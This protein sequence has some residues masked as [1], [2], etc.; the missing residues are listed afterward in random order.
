MDPLK[1]LGSLLGNNATSSGP[2]GQIL[3]QLLDG[4][5]RGGVQSSGAG[6]GLTDLLGSLTRSSA[7]SG[8]AGGG[9]TDLLGS[10]TK[11]GAQSSGAGGGLADLLG[12]LTGGVRPQGSAAPGGSNMAGVLGSLAMIALQMFSQR[13]AASGQSSLAALALTDAASGQTPPAVDAAQAHQQALAF[14]KAMINAAKADGQIDA[15]EQEKI[16][17][18][19]GD[20]DPQEAAFI[21]DEISKPLNFDFF[22]DITQEMTPQ[23]YAVSLMAI[24]LDTPAEISYMQQLA[25]GLGLD[26]QAVN[27]IH[28]QLG[29]APLYG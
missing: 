21:R 17:S 2:G 25:Q 10:L 27:G 15:E 4:L 11:G 1:L 26:A 28:A 7:Q 13:G 3:G 24:S 12:S 29:L 18:R 19:L 9:L 16:V 20:I 5:T 14:I 23:I 6:G 22:A 8:G